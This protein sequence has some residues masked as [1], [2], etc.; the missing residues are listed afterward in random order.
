MSDTSDPTLGWATYS[1]YYGTD[2]PDYPLIASSTDKIVV[3]DDL[4]DTTNAFAFEFSDVLTLT[5]ASIL[6]NGNITAAECDAS[7]FAHARAAQ[8]LCRAPIS[9]S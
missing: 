5:W 3:T 4:Y 2:L 6:L 9:T 8:V 7:A 1:F